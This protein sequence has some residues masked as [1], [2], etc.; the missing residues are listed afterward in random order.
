MT[1]DCASQQL[2]WTVGQQGMPVP[3]RLCI[4]L[5]LHVLNP[6]RMAGGKAWACKVLVSSYTW[7]SPAAFHILKG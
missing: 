6:G 7:R 2:C 4:L 1:V 3:V 5:C